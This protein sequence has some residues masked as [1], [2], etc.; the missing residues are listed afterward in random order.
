MLMDVL[1]I[2]NEEIILVRRLIGKPAGTQ[3]EFPVSWWRLT[4]MVTCEEREA[5]GILFISAVKVD[6]K[7]W[8]IADQSKPEGYGVCICSFQSGEYERAV[9]EIARATGLGLNLRLIP[10]KPSS[11]L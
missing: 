1:S 5:H 9:E 2:E 10:V 3:L 8:V 6:G 7:R 4:D 11:H